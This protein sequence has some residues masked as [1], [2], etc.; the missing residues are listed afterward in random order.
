MLGTAIKADA[1][2]PLV[3]LQVPLTA[4]PLAQP[5]V[6][7]CQHSLLPGVGSQLASAPVIRGLLTVPY[8]KQRAERGEENNREMMGKGRMLGG[9]PSA[10]GHQSPVHTL[11]ALL[12]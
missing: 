2:G 9:E 11:W 3:T 6:P 10:A 1:E 12:K 4:W 5:C 8:S 7:T